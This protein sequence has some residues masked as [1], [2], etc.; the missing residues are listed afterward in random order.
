MIM[1]PISV[2]G[3]FSWQGEPIPE[4]HSEKLTLRCDALP[5]CASNKSRPKSFQIAYMPELMFTR[6]EVL[7]SRGYARGSRGVQ[8]TRQERVS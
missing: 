4:R 6:E 5:S 8:K 1:A 2:M 7:K 3:A